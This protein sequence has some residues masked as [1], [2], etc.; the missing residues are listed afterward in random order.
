M[1][2]VAALKRK[3][4]IEAQEEQLR[5]E[6]ERLEL[7]TEMAAANAKIQVLEANSSRDNSRVS[8]G[9]RSYF[10]KANAQPISTL[11]PIAATYIPEKRLTNI[12]PPP[13]VVRPKERM[14]ERMQERIP[15]MSVKTNA[16]TRVT[17]QEQETHLKSSMH[18]HTHA[19]RSSGGHVHSQ[20]PMLSDNS[21]GDIIN[22]MERQNDI[23][24]L[25]VQQNLSSSLPP[26]DI[27]PFNGDPLQYQ[28]FMR[29]FENGVEEK[30]TNLGDCLH[31]LEQYTRGQPR[32][33]VQSCQ[34]LPPDQGYQRAK[35]L[36][37]EHFGN[38]QKISSA[39]MDKVFSWTPIKGED[40]Q[41]LQ[42]FA[43]FLRGCC[44]AT[45]NIMYMKELDFPSNMR[46]IVLKLPYKFRERWRNT[47]CDLRERRGQ[48][49]LFSDLVSFIERQVRIV[50]DPL[51]GNIHESQ[52]VTSSKSFPPKQIRETRRHKGSSFA[53]SVT[54]MEGKAKTAWR[55]KKESSSSTSTH[56]GCLFCKGSGH[57][58]DKCSQFKG[59]IHRDK[60]NFI[61]E[62]GICFGCLQ[63]GHISKDC[64]SRLECNV[65]SQR[66]P[67]ILHIEHQDKGT[68]AEQSEQPANSTVGTAAAAPQT[69]GHIGAGC[70]DDSIFSIVPVQVKCQKGDK[71]L[72]TYAFLDPGSSGTFC[73]NSLAQRLNV[74]RRRTRFLL[75]TMG[76][77]KTVDSYAIS[78]LAVSGL[79]QTDFIELPDVFTQKCMPVTKLNIPKQ[80]DVNKWPYLRH[81]ELHEIDSDI[82]L[83]IG[84]NASELMEPWELVN[85]QRGGPYAVRTKVGWVLNGPLRGGRD[86]KKDG[87]SAVTPNRISIA[88]IEE[89]LV[90]QYNHDFSERSSEEQAEMSRDDI[91][92]MNIVDSSAVLKDG[93]YTLDLPFRHENSILPN[94]R[95]VAEQRLTSLKRKFGKNEVFKEEYISFLSDVIDQGYAEIV[96]A[97]ELNQN[98]GRVWYIPHHGVYHP[99][100]GKLRVVFDC[101]AVYKGTSL[102]CQLLPGPNL[103]NSLIGVLIRFRQE[104]V[105]VMADIQSMFHQARVSA[106][107]INFLR[108]LWWPQGDTK[109]APVEYRMTVHL[110]G[111]V[112]S[113]SCANYALRKTADDNQSHFSPEVV[114]T[115]KCNFYVDD[116]LKSLTSEEEAVQ[117]VKD[118][119]DLCQK[120]GFNLSKWMS[121]SRRILTSVPEE[122]RAKEVKELDLDKDS[123][124]LERA[125]GLQWCV[126]SDKFKFR[127]TVKE[128]PQTR[129]GIL[130]V[131]SSLYDPL[132]FLAPFTLPAK[133]ILQELCKRSYGWDEE[134]PR[135]FS[136]QWF[137]WLQGLGKISEF[138]VDRCFGHGA[139]AQ[140]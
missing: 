52:P 91:K 89:M 108:F 68:S 47:A 16:Q 22:I 125:L 122:S 53:T 88:N 11:N 58:L 51:F 72:Q 24:T 121:N 77:E 116:C 74:S 138:K 66:H 33:I 137:D 131:V 139:A 46:N 3:H 36:L 118:L 27:P 101:G 67:G 44:N 75:R 84:T 79:D 95:C 7:E 86:S 94:N 19:Q 102:N 14:Q 85:S 127:I 9:M 136:Q 133:L 61:K 107:D 55:E 38:E 80:E 49:A 34:H 63:M 35:N 109:Q 8:D 69:C 65:C 5:K 13:L 110:F 48:R 56:Q 129:R 60:I 28:A 43:L 6:K 1:E 123:L 54:A 140:T 4:Q 96:P 76:Q 41:A 124:P 39:Y 25:L 71:V 106:K 103:T 73:T 119:T 62:K 97:E 50:S 42:A 92:F 115:V 112:S 10:E 21:Q 57:S 126:D 15:K 120:G 40:V 104:P 23:T 99:R 83:L 132:G 81:I 2:R 87:C 90:N 134:I 78:G 12:L 17:R 100:K 135:Y 111:A 30:T 130:S 70:E 59:K 20:T 45:E 82:D 37:R 18:A 128:R 26:R 105:A 93:H 29:A 32:D 64:R 117:M 113:P 114:S 98:D 31:Y